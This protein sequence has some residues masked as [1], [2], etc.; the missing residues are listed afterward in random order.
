MLLNVENGKAIQ[1]RTYQ[2]KTVASNRNYLLIVSISVEPIT[3][4]SMKLNCCIIDH[5]YATLL[6]WE[7]Q[8][9]YPAVHLKIQEGA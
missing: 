7:A 9:A 2:L 4:R 3:L 1:E 8:W 5:F 6:L